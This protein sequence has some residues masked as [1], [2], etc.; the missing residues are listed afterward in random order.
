MT[1]GRSRRVDAAPRGGNYLVGSTSGT[2]RPAPCWGPRT[3]WFRSM[4][5]A[6]HPDGKWLAIADFGN[7]SV[8]LW[9][10]AAGTLITRLRPRSPVAWRLPRTA[11]GWHH[12]AMTAASTLPTLEPA[13]RCWCFGVSD[14]R[15]APA[16]GRHGSPIQR[17]RHANR[18]P[19]GRI[20]QP[21][22]GQPADRR[23]DRAETRRR[24]GLDAP[25][26]IIRHSGRP[27]HGAGRIRTS[28]GDSGRP[29]RAVDQAWARPRASS[30]RRQRRPSPG[31]SRS[32]CDDPLRWLICARELE[33][34]QPPA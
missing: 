34:S 21:L 14:H 2:P 16:A 3:A 23:A 31:R 7:A 13:S 18:R 10:V 24:C 29:S 28:P 17:R 22:G 32:T 30:R 4:Y 15:P 6:F 11:G 19:P 9:D 20:S 27:Y 33:G 5:L 26:P 1:A 8:H 12:W 25:Q